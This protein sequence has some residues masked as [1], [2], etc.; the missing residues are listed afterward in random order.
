M[1]FQYG[2]HRAFSSTSQQNDYICQ[3]YFG[4]R[5]IPYKSINILLLCVCVFVN[6]RWIIQLFSRFT[7]LKGN[8]HT[9]LRQ[10]TQHNKT[11]AMQTNELC[12]CGDD[13][14][15]ICNK[16]HIR[17]ITAVQSICVNNMLQFANM[18]YFV[19]YQHILFR[20]FASFSFSFCVKKKLV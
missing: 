12:R 18:A 13:K 6:S 19:A 16:G 15:L 20:A 11:K 3:F 8:A 7:R 10:V 2:L 5:I 1:L 17:I 4:Q 14:C 9:D